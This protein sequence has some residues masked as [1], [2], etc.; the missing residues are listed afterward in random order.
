RHR[1]RPQRRAHRHAPRPGGRRRRDARR[2]RDPLGRRAGR[3]ARAVPPRPGRRVT[4]LGGCTVATRSY[5][6]DARLAARSFLDHHPGARFTIVVVDGEHMPPAT[7]EHRDVELVTPQQLGFPTDEL[8][9]MAA[10]Y[11][12]AEMACAFKPLALRRTL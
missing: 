7:W 10:I 3:R 6:A 1:H 4:L 11:D 5:L 2:G 12:P 9:R 8:H